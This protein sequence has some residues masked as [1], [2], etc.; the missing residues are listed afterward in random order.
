MNALLRVIFLS[1]ERGLTQPSSDAFGRVEALGE[2]NLKLS[3]IVLP[4]TKAEITEQGNLRAIGLTGPA[5]VR[6]WKAFRTTLKEVRRARKAGEQPV[7]SAQDPFIAGSIVFTV[8]RLLNVPYEVQEHGDYFSG[9]W[10]REAPL[11]HRTWSLIGRAILRRADG[12]RVVSERI[13]DHLVQQG[14]RAE[15]IIVT[16]VVKDLRELLARTPHPW[17]TTP[18]IVV[19][20]RFVKQ[21]GL[22]TLLKALAILAKEGRAFRVRLVGEGPEGPRVAAMADQLGLRDRISFEQWS[23]SSSI[24]ADADLFVLSSNYEGWGRTIAEAM[25]AGV[26]V[27]TTDVGCVGSFFR[28]QVDGRVVPPGDAAALA[29]AMREQFTEP[30][31]RDEMVKNARA[32]IT[33]LPSVADLRTTQRQA[34]QNASQVTTNRRVWMVTVIIILAALAVRLLAVALFADPAGGTREWGFFNLIAH[35]FQGTGY[36]FV[37]IPGHVSAYRSP[38]FLFFLTVVYT[39]FGFPNFL[40]Q[41][42][43]QALLAVLLTYLIYRLGWRIA[44]NRIVGWIAALLVTTHPYTFY[45]Y[46]QYYHT[47]L[48]GLFLVSLL[49]CLLAL[50][51]TKQY[52]WAIW[53][54]VMTAGLAYIQGTIL[55]AMPFLALWLIWRWRKDLKRAILATMLIAVVSAGLIAPWTIRNWQAFHAFVPLTTDLG[56]AVYKANNENYERLMDAGYQHEALEEETNPTDPTLVRY[57]YI[58]EVQALLESTGGITPSAYWTEWHPIE[59]SPSAMRVGSQVTEPQHS[60]HWMALAHAWIVAHPTDFARVALKKAIVLWQPALYPSLKYGAAWS[61]GN[62]GIKATLAR[63][64]LIVYVAILELLALVG[65]AFAWRRKQAGLII[66]ILI[67]FAVYTVMHMLLAPYTKYRIP[68]DNLVAIL[69]A[70]PFAAV[71]MRL[72]T[73]T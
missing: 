18:T 20:C 51:R 19:P 41:Y 3:A 42:I 40:A 25:A 31:R 46:T 11:T 5:P 34:W 73:K 6:L 54:G 70:I 7:L 68:L 43:I 38:G 62:E 27:V 2:A 35:F 9:M 63:T 1:Y 28:P 59:P 50:E 4:A 14:V 23:D 26:P 49:L 10:V 13:R 56:F 60:A 17:T 52:R 24:W 57:R 32:R 22:D 67:V 15:R 36:S 33:D 58:P 30:A 39:M 44:Q 12:V 61:F 71:W 16:P 53:T 8:S 69:A 21:K 64:S 72:R 47:V 29:A 65:L 48:S 55:P 45:H 66:P 37:D